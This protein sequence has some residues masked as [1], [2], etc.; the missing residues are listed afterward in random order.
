VEREESETRE[1]RD[2]KR[3]AARGMEKDWDG[4]DGGGTAI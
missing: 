3:D 4:G 2:G 1:R